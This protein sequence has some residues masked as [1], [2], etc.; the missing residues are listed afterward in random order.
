M[1]TAEEAS[2]TR[3]AELLSQMIAMA[4]QMVETNKEM[5]TGLR[6]STTTSSTSKSAT[7]SLVSPSP[8]ST[9]DDSKSTTARSA[10]PNAALATPITT[11]DDNKHEATVATNQPASPSPAPLLLSLSTIPHQHAALT[12]QFDT[13]E[14]QPQTHAKCS[15]FGHVQD[16]SVLKP[17]AMPSAPSLTSTL[18]QNTAC[19]VP[20]TVIEISQV[21]TTQWLSSSLVNNMC[22]QGVD[23]SDAHTV[24]EDTYSSSFLSCAG[25][26]GLTTIAQQQTSSK[27]I[28]HGIAYRNSLTAQTNYRVELLLELEVQTPWDP[29][30]MVDSLTCFAPPSI[31][32]QLLNS[33]KQL[34]SQCVPPGIILVLASMDYSPFLFGM[35]NNKDSLNSSWEMILNSASTPIEKEKRIPLLL[36]LQMLELGISAEFSGSIDINYTG[37]H[38]WAQLQLS[39]FR[40]LKSQRNQHLEF[41]EYENFSRSGHTVAQLCVISVPWDPGGFKLDG[42]CA[43]TAWGQAVF[44]EGKYV[45]DPDMGVGL[46]RDMDW[47]PKRRGPPI[48]YKRESWEQQEGDRSTTA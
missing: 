39:A 24:F 3:C 47:G 20:L 41:Q 6:V 32:V 37:T 30:D 33:D 42:Y 19:A 1:D 2:S 43:T 29:S 31:L 11:T 44:Q 15:M 22:I 23:V 14:L 13:T 26:S 7:T 12:I 45:I 40:W 8:S 38:E 27:Y 9:N 28:V 16:A 5:L 25:C 18:P 35:D 17:V 4:K 21:T 10:A 36:Q 34:A 46:V 48:C